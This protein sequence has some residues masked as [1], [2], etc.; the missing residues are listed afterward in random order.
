MDER[1]AIVSRMFVVLGLILLLPS[2]I[3]L[4]QLRINFVEGDNLRE[5]WNHQTINYVNIPAQ[6]GNIFDANG[7]LLATNSIEY[8]LAVD[9]G[10]SGF[11][12]N[13]LTLL[14]TTLSSHTGRSASWYENQVRNA[15]RQSRYVVLERNMDAQTYVE[16]HEL[17]IPGVIL[18]EEYK[19]NYSFGS[20]AAHALGF[21]NHEL[22]G[23]SGLES[24]Y[25][26]LLKGEDGLQQVRRDRS[27]RIF[28]YVGAP[29]KTPI[30]GHSLHT[31]LDSYMQA[32][33][34]EELEEGIRETRS[35]YGTGIIIEPET[36]AVKAI[37]NY[38][39]FDPNQPGSIDSENR[40]NYAVADMVEPGSTFKLV[41]AIAAVEQGVVNFEEQFVTPENGQINI[42][43]QMMRDHD[44]L[45]T[46]DFTQAIAKSS[47]I[48]VSEIAMRLSP[49]IFYQ[50]A[51]NLGFGTPTHIDL[52][53]ETAGRLQKPY[54]WSRV[55]LP[56]MSIGYEV[57]A[58][59]LQM[60]QAYAAFANDGMMMRPHIVSHIT[61]EYGDRVRESR[62]VEIRRIA[63]MSTIEK[64]KP[65][66]EAVVTDSGTA[67]WAFVEGLP[68]AGKTGTAQ[69]YMDGRYQTAYRA[70]FVGFFPSDDPKYTMIVM[71]DEPR[72]SIYGGYTAGQIF[73]D[74]AARV[75]GLDS[76]IQRT[77]PESIHESE[78]LITIAPSVTGFRVEEAQQLLSNQRITWSTSG[79][80]TR[81]VSQEPAAGDTVQPGSRMVLELS[82]FAPDSTGELV[83]VPDLRNKSIR[84]A[85]SMLSDLGLQIQIIGSGT[86]YAQFPQP[87][88][89]MRRGRTITVRGKARS[90]EQAASPTIT[91]IQ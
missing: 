48:A 2:F 51:R 45:G 5:L 8:R 40:R 4:Q 20:L 14:A 11:T 84:Q 52:P 60:L 85:S 42:H 28:A 50:Y 62:P 70:S 7:S 3:L 13:H 10:F 49:Q 34:E 41:T 58:S 36:G 17:D 72:T 32:I 83:T 81:V 1:T 44:P 73:R 38:P 74:I 26:D 91:S 57:Q 47:N 80:G 77:I 15:P 65:V 24:Y 78:S 90:L 43:G 67:G 53:N 29:R 59:P 12:S 33:L 75:A 69:K 88:E 76:D 54:E 6:R 19:R 22:T 71:L 61:D 30:Q 35:T 31:T 56:W 87:G 55:T 23:M 39:A 64:L 89:S 79:T 63:E 68:I 46:L 82:T 37:A 86:I 21:V 27:N 18:E 9:P 16:I 25:D 66:F